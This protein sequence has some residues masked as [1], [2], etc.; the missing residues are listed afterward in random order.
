MDKPLS[1]RIRWRVDIVALGGD[2]I[3]WK[4]RRV[5]LGD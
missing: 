3:L 5:S 1:S 2:M 4:L